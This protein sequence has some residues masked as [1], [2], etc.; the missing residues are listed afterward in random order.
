MNCTQATI[1]QLDTIERIYRACGARL[2]EQGFHNWGDFYPPRATIINDIQTQ[3]LWVLSANDGELLGMVVVDKIEPAV[4]QSIRW[5]W[6]TPH[7]SYIHRLAVSPYQQG[8]GFAVRL[9]LEAER[10]ARQRGSDAMR[11]DAY[12]INS[13][14]LRFYEKLGYR[15]T[16]QSV[17]LGEPWLHPFICFEKTFK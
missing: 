8:K 7:A 9:M 2:A 11:L 6:Q 17:E 10:I 5:H 1:E 15:S 13:Q 16:G 3:N 4:Y 12:S 14:L